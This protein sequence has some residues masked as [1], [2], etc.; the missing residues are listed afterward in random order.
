MVY[1]C[2]PNTEEK[3]CLYHT[4]VS[5]LVFFGGGREIYLHMIHN[6]YEERTD[7]LD[8]TTV[9]TQNLVLENPRTRVQR[10]R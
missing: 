4:K 1:P 5:N 9:G 8:T 3:N 7:S 2:I 10:T 6:H